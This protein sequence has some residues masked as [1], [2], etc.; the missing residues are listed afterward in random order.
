MKF[1]VESLVAAL[2]VAAAIASYDSVANAQS[3]TPLLAADGT[4]MPDVGAP[5][6]RLALGMNVADVLPIGDDNS[7]GQIALATA[8][9]AGF[10]YVNRQVTNMFVNNNGNITFNNPVPTFTPIPFP[11]SNNPMV[12]PFWAD[13]DT[14]NGPAAPALD[15]RVY[16]D[17]RRGR[18]TVTWYRVGYYNS[19]PSHRNNFQLV[20]TSQAN[21][22]M[23][24]PDGRNYDIEF[25]YGNA[26]GQALSWYVG[27]ASNG[28][29]QGL[30]DLN[31]M[32]VP[33]NPQCIPAQAGFDGGDLASV[34]YLPH[35][36]TPQVL[37]LS[38][39]SNVGIPGVWRFPVRD[40][41]APGCG[42]GNLNPGEECDDGNTRSGDGCSSTCR[43]ERANGAACTVGGQCRSGN[44]VD[45]V[46]CD[47]VCNG[48][49]EACNRAGRLGTCGAVTGAPVAPRAACGGNMG[50]QCSLTCDGVNRMACTAPAT[51]TGA[52]CTT[53]RCVMGNCTNLVSQCLPPTT[54]NMGS[55]TCQGCRNNGDCGGATPFCDLTLMP[56][57]CVACRNAADCGG[58]TP[59]CDPTRRVCVG[60]ATN[61][62]C[63][64]P[65]PICDNAAGGSFTCIGCRGNN[66]C[67]GA[68]PICNPVSRRCVACRNNGDC[69][70]PTPICS[71][72]NTCVACLNNGDCNG[73][74]PFCNGVT[75]TC[76]ACRNS[77][78]C[79][80][81][82]PVCN[83]LTFVCSPC[84]RNADCPASAPVCNVMTGACRGCVANADCR[85][86]T[87]VCDAPRGQCVGCNNNAD[88]GG[89]TPV[90][91]PGRRVCVGCVDN[92]SCRA[93]TPLCD[94]GLNACVACRSSADCAG[95]TPVCEP[96]RR[97]CVGCLGDPDCRAPTPLC[98]VASNTCAGCLSD[99]DCGGGTP[100][101]EPMRR[102]CVACRTNMDCGG[103]TPICNTM[104][105]VCR[106]C[107]P[108]N[109]AMDCPN[110]NRPF[111][112]AMGATSGTCVQAPPTITNPMN[113]SSS[114]NTRPVIRGRASPG[115][116]VRVYLDGVAIGDVMADMDGNWSLNAPGVG[117]GMHTVVAANVDA[118]VVGPQ[119][120][121]STFTVTRCMAAADCSGGTPV[122]DAMS[123]LCRPCDPLN[124]MDCRAPRPMC[125]VG[126]ANAGRC[127]ATV[128]TITSPMDG[129]MTASRRPEI[130]GVAAP[131]STVSV[132]IDGMEVG[133]VMTDADGNFV[134]TPMMDLPAG[135]HTI[136]AAPV[137]FAGDAGVDAGVVGMPGP[138]I[139]ITV[140]NC[141]SSAECSGGTPICEPGT[142]MCRACD[143][144]REA[145]DCP[146]AMA[147][148]CETM[149]AN[150]GRCVVRPPHITMPMNGT[151]SATKRPPITGTGTPGR[152]V[153][154]TV[155]GMEV[156]RV[157]VD[158]MG[159]WSFT[160]D[161]DLPTGPVTI[162]VSDVDAMG[163]VLPPADSVM[164]TIPECVMDNECMPAQRCDMNTGR[165][166]DRMADAGI[167]DTGITMDTGVVV[168]S[169]ARDGSAD[170][171][172]MDSG[173]RPD[174]SLPT[175]GTISGDG[176][177]GCRAVGHSSG[178]NRG[179]LALGAAVALTLTARRR[180][181]AS[182]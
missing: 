136:A 37:L 54:C 13:V 117:A 5:T 56:T 90:C 8:W 148:K 134:F 167:A 4:A 11:I 44:C 14:R 176:L 53:G 62:D 23:G 129:A 109:A 107:N 26:M 9:P 83:P 31:M 72:Q 51:C 65:T 108:A 19:N 2:G 155:N 64:A 66:D 27:Q 110:A 75:N 128:P 21:N 154:I 172:N 122:C 41:G 103:A 20:V 50:M 146:N 153:V 48:Q 96:M 157:M 163:M 78:D 114:T 36:R 98:D 7:S 179:L 77:G 159:N 156:G 160:P 178:S 32:G 143:V 180:R 121:P 164:I 124:A 42:D 89:A 49:C 130:R 84:T 46:C 113:G 17:L 6:L 120:M 57:R 142:M 3:N 106:A 91:D 131:N 39:E 125:A 135:M 69:R 43:I 34:V 52:N 147:P 151:M 149:G 161:R 16:W 102:V 139:R 10:C 94:L 95:A 112:S 168:D 118:M 73:A 25:R 144:M 87:P 182:R 123:M 126:G 61:M 150:A 76:V 22:A 166:I 59:V 105:N 140:T 24:L 15:D 47:S 1:S 171:G 137:T 68:T 85:A 174:S 138:S 127:V 35:S 67:G 165:C 181:N 169:G 145:T 116:L 81:N 111:C 175:G 141:A 115:Q 71:P 63:A 88:C 80:G 58:A 133:Q 99:A 170:A 93:P 119:G 30:C 100:V 173:I 38:N 158:A 86:P 101:C 152:T 28:N 82:T 74:T 18:M 40:C 92:T 45:G 33:S 177:C 29:A 60:C 55:N 104:T 162:E 79:G 12:A 132:R 70:N 97:V